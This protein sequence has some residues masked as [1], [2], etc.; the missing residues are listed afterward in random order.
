MV[1][2]MALKALLVPVHDDGLAQAALVTTC[3][4]A[5][6]YACYV[7]GLTLDFTRPQALTVDMLGG[8]WMPPNHDHQQR[9]MAAS[10]KIFVDFMEMAGIAKAAGSVDG[11]SYHWHD[12]EVDE[13]GGIAG[14]GRAFDLTVY[15][16]AS[17]SALSASGAHLEASLFESGRPI[18]LAPPRQPSTIGEHVVIAWN[19]STESARTV[20]FAMPLLEQAKQITILTIE[21]GVVPGP[22]AR[23]LARLLQ[24]NGITAKLHDAR[25]RGRT[26][27]AA[28]LEEAAAVGCDLLIKGAYTQSRLRQMIFGG[29]TS[30]ILVS[31]EIP[32]FMAN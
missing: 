6:R 30:H 13:I 22:N 7:E 17:A 10:R 24:V 16:R 31:A 5:K 25:P 11:P 9:E 26:T 32:V 23:E 12:P 19:C 1:R 8:A 20:A 28:I 27:G 15:N 2:T 14:Y 18:L 3:A 21:G 29:A 4:F